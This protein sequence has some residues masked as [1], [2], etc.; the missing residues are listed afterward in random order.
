MLRPGIVCAH[1]RLE[2]LCAL[3]QATWLEIYTR[4]HPESFARR[5]MADYID[6]AIIQRQIETGFRYYFLTA[7][8]GNAGYFGFCK[9]PDKVHLSKLYIHSAFQGQG[10]GRH[11]LEFVEA[12]T[13]EGGLGLIDLTCAK[14]NERAV[15]MYEAFG[16][17]TT[18]S[19]SVSFDGQSGVEL[20]MEK[21]FPRD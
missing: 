2:E 11:A 4:F 18:R 3:A 10:I 17:R 1:G 21:R 9:L 12:F 19:V 20:T 15:G 14:V 13:R 5:I 8:E 7:G 6:P 16:Y